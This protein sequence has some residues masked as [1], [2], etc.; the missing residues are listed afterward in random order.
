VYGV[1]AAFFA[2][3]VGGAGHGTST[4]L[5]L[6]GSP[7]T[8]FGQL[9]FELGMPDLGASGNMWGLMVG[10]LQ[11]GVLG[12]LFSRHVVGRKFFIGY[13]SLHYVVA[14]FLL[15]KF[16]DW[17]YARRMSLPFLIIAYGFYAAGQ[18]SIWWLI[19]R[20]ARVPS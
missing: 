1:I 11:W 10:A 15:T 13:L 17:E 7:I 16:G 18:F 4:L 2:I 6:V 9:G 8:G 5:Q 20:T 19:L 14:T 3:M 12:T